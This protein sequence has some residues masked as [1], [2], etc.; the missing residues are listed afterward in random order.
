[1]DTKFGWL[2]IQ[3]QICIKLDK[4]YC[5]NDDFHIHNHKLTVDVVKLLSVTITVFWRSTSEI[6]RGEDDGITS[7]SDCTGTTG[8]INGEYLLE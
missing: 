3:Y 5:P 7:E 8:T 1:M 6:N 4:N 2:P